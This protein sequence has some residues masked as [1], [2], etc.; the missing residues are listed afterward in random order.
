MSMDLWYDLAIR[1]RPDLDVDV[2]DPGEP[3]DAEAE[4][5]PDAE[6]SGSVAVDFF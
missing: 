6:A 3:E 1:E 4:R 5:A 2:V